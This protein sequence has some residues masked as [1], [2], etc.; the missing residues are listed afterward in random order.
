MRSRGSS[1][2]LRGDKGI[3]D[4][5]TIGI[6]SLRISG[7]VVWTLIVNRFVQ[8]F[9]DEVEFLRLSTNV[10]G[11]WYA[12]QVYLME[13]CVF[14][15]HPRVFGTTHTVMEDLAVDTVIGVVA[16][17]FTTTGE[18]GVLEQQGQG[19]GTL[20]FFRFFIVPIQ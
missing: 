14:R 19:V 9:I 18:L 17:L 11:V 2:F 7:G 4:D 10:L 13:N 8:V 20:F 6:I 15:A 3:S 16:I 5:V 1:L 12:V